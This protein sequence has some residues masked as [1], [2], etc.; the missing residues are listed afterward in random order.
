MKKNR[1]YTFAAAI[2]LA[3]GLVSCGDSFLTEEPASSVPIKGYYTD[4][5]KMIEAMAAAY[6]PMQWFDYY[7]GWFPGMLQAM[8]FTR[9]VATRPTRVIFTKSPGMAVALPMT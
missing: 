6:D 1:L 9:V 8:I 7:N 4:N 2:L 3:S 5:A